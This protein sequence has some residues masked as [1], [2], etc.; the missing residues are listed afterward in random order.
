MP[1]QTGQQDLANRVNDNARRIRQL[2]ETVR[3][4]QEQVKSLEDQVNQQKRDLTN[5][6]HETKEQFEQVEETLDTIDAEVKNL[7]RKTRKLVTRREFNE[8]EE[9]MDLMNPVQS[10]FLTKSEAETII[11]KKLAERLGERR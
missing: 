6:E 9:Y 2:E 5:H 1:R 8:M 10:S 3:N 7:Q 4:L 11:E